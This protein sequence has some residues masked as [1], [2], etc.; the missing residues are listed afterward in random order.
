MTRPICGVGALPDLLQA[1]RGGERVPSAGTDQPLRDPFRLSVDGYVAYLLLSSRRIAER[2]ADLWPSVR[3][4]SRRG[5]TDGGRG[6]GPA[7]RHQRCIVSAIFSMGLCLRGSPHWCRPPPRRPG[8]RHPPH[9]A[10]PVR[11]R[12]SGADRAAR[13]LP[14]RL[15]PAPSAA[16][17]VRAGGSCSASARSARARRPG[18]MSST[19]LSS[20]RSRIPRAQAAPRWPV[21]CS[22]PPSSGRHRGGRPGVREDPPRDW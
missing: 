1:C 17:P 6:R 22:S 20:V 7:S 9:S 16:R 15:C 2:R 8:A 3:A 19:S 13:R 21:A 4:T 10:R 14:Q 12:R 18:W 11:H 5:P